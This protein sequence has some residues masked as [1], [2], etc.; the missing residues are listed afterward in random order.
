MSFPCI[1][2]HTVGVYLVLAMMV[3]AIQVRGMTGRIPPGSFVCYSTVAGPAIVISVFSR[4]WVTTMT[5]KRITC[6]SWGKMTEL[7]L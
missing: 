1:P 5:R 7:I 3:E 2:A 4:E 6:S